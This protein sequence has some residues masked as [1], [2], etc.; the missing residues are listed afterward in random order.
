MK[1]I[2]IF[3]LLLL[4]TLNLVSENS[5][6]EIVQKL[7][8]TIENWFGTQY[9]YGGESKDGTDCSGF[10]AQVYKEV[11]NIDLPRSVREQRKLGKL[12]TNNLEPGDLLFFKINDSISHVGIYVFDSKFIHAASQGPSIGVIKSSLKEKYYKTRYVFAKRIIT[13]P[14]YVKEKDE[15]EKSETPISNNKY[16]IIFGKILFKGKL[17]DT[18]DEFISKNP[19]YLQIKNENKIL[20]KYKI[21]LIDEKTKNITYELNINNSNKQSDIKK[22]FLDKGIYKV[23]LYNSFNKFITEN[24]IKI[25]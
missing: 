25:N 17:L 8:S 11:F 7:F 9:I 16:E 23:K 18:S 19:I 22:I 4:L 5:R 13:L 1:K 6:K 14:P 10:V 2:I 20:N 15:K 24:I 12:V 21:I 3:L